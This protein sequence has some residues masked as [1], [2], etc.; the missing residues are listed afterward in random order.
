MARLNVDSLLRKISFDADGS[1]GATLSRAQDPSVAIST[2]G[3][4]ALPVKA[5]LALSTALG[6][7]YASVTTGTAS[8]F[9]VTGAA[10]GDLVLVLPNGTALGGLT[11]ACNFAGYVSTA[12]T[13]TVYAQANTGTIDFTLTTVTIIVIKL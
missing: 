12:N 1:E 8:T 6:S 11:A 7:A 9:T 13:V 2:A 5:L 3:G 10:V 4:A